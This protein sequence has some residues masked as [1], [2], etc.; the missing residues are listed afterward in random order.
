MMKKIFAVILALGILTGCGA[1]AEK[2]SMGTVSM[3]GAFELKCTLPEGYSLETV[4]TEANA[5][6]ATVR[7]EDP[8]RPVMFIS[9][10]YNELYSETERLNDLDDESFNAVLESFREEDEVEISEMETA[11]GTKVL[12]VREAEGETDFVDFY[13]IYKGYEVEMVLTHI[14]PDGTVTAPVTAEE[15]DMAIRFLSDLDFIGE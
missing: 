11:Y 12:V 9:I 1:L 8:S 15:I 13:S 2:E 6:L 7:S 10:A 14:G 3:N 4:S 5:L